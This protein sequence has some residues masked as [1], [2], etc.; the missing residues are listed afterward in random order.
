[1]GRFPYTVKEEYFK[2]NDNQCCS[3]VGTWFFHRCPKKVKEFIDGVGFCG[4]HARS[5]KHWRGDK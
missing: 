5:I 3:E 4:I 2:L 1:M